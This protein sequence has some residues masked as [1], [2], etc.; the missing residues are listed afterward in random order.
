MTSQKDLKLYIAKSG[1]VI[2]ANIVNFSLP[3][4]IAKIDKNLEKLLAKSEEQK[5][6]EPEMK[7]QSE[8]EVEKKKEESQAEEVDV[9][10]S[11]MDLDVDVS[12]DK[13]RSE[14]QTE[15]KVKREM[16][17]L[18]ISDDEPRIELASPGRRESK[19]PLKYRLDDPVNNPPAKKPRVSKAARGAADKS[20]ND[21]TISEPSEEKIDLGVSKSE[22]ATPVT[23]VA[24]PG[25]SFVAVKSVPPPPTSP[26]P[27][28]EPT[29]ESSTSL[30]MLPTLGVGTFAIDEETAR[31]KPV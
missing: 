14:Q 30:K 22:T 31:S 18:G 20:L 9:S 23:E 26:R 29:Y 24:T 28:F 3:K 13:E 10:I 7:A 16:K 19:L 27:G 2:D 25:P 8:P 21:S 4:K 6:P 12:V 5:P 15:R 17:K 1:A 11:D